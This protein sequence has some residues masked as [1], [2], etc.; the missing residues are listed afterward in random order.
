MLARE[1]FTP[2]AA[3]DLRDA[4][5]DAGGNEVFVAGR[6]DERGMVSEVVVAARGGKASVPAISGFL[7]RGD[8]LIHNHP[9]GFLVPSDEI[10]RAHV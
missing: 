7:N 4:I 6:L 9:S 8:V 10:G 2:D 3:K 5:S 1:R